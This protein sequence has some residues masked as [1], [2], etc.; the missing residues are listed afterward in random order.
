MAIIAEFE[1][2]TTGS[3]LDRVLDR[4]G[5]DAEL[6][7]SLL[8]GD[9][10]LVVLRVARDGA[11][12]LDRAA[13]ADRGVADPCRLGAVDDAV[14]YRLAVAGA[15]PLLAGGQWLAAGYADGRWSVTARFEG[16]EAFADHRE[17][18]EADGTAVAV[19]GLYDRR[20]NGGLTDRQRETLELAYRQGFFEV[21]RGTT[22][23]ELGEELGVS[24]QAVSQRLRRG[25][26]HLVEGSLF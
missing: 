23:R 4:A 22:M 26:A 8:L 17:A 2:G 20:E 16:R 11:D 15:A 24:E 10:S 21:P 19:D 18:L 13:A 14:L 25:Y 6:L 5:V 1:V 9:R 3:A 12:A 7:R